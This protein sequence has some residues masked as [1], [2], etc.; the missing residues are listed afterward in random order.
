MRKLHNSL[1]NTKQSALERHKAAQTA[2]EK[3]N[4]NINAM[5][6]AILAT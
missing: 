2:N 3:I 1:Q 4:F 6:G 5:M